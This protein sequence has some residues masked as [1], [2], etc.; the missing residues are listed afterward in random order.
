M[1]VNTKSANSYKYKVGQQIQITNGCNGNFSHY[2]VSKYTRG[3]GEY[4]KK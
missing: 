2:R 4:K 3:E 1:A